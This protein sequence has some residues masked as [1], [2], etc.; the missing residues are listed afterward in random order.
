[1]PSALCQ[2]RSLHNISIEIYS[3]NIFFHIIHANKRSEVTY[4]AYMD[5][6]FL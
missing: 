6:C 3:L 2:Q 5:H 1:M 4:Y